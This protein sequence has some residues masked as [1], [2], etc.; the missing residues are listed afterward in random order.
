M[1]D[2]STL[3]KQYKCV[4][5]NMARLEAEMKAKDLHAAIASI[6]SLMEDYIETICSPSINIDALLDKSIEKDGNFLHY[7]RKSLRSY[8]SGDWN[9]LE[10]S[11]RGFQVSLQ[12]VWLSRL[13][14]GIKI[15][16]FDIINLNMRKAI[17]DIECLADA[18]RWAVG[19]YIPE[20]SNGSTTAPRR[21][22]DTA[23][24]KGDIEL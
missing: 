17:M 1:A 10:S 4:T 8:L 6:E 24:W 21:R 16:H 11:H 7:T 20:W 13:P 3:S 22:E 2:G 19:C 9:Y 12:R 23:L 15:N 14:D 5:V 18:V